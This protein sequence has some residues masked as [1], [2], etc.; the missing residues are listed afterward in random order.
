MRS[1]QLSIS[2][3]DRRTLDK[4]QIDFDFVHAFV[5]LVL[6]T[7]KITKKRAVHRLKIQI[8]D[9]ECSTYQFDNNLYIT[10]QC[11]SSN[12]GKSKYLFFNDLMHELGHYIQ[13]KV[14][15]VPFT[16]FAVDHETQSYTKYYNNATERQ[17]RKYGNLSR[18]MIQLYRKLDALRKEC[19]Q[20]LNSSSW[21][22]RKNVQ[23]KQ[24][25]QKKKSA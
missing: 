2:S 17:A 18:E 14:D 8:V 23:K 13:Y 20:P 10:Q 9:D 21:K 5:A 24:K 25:K 11:F 4:Y 19:A 6:N 12:V 3:K 16:M 1:V 22:P 15:R 7:I